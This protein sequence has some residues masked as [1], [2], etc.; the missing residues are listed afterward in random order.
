L[1]DRAHL[2]AQI[3]H[4][5]RNPLHAALGLLEY[6]HGNAGGPAGAACAPCALRPLFDDRDVLDIHSLETELRTMQSVLNA[7]VDTQ[8]LEA[9]LATVR[10]GPTDLPAVVRDVC[11]YHRSAL[12]NGVELEV[13]LA[14]NI[15]VIQSDGVRIGQVR[16]SSEFHVLGV[17]D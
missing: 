10:I 16:R 6:M 7:V 13:C 5:L 3:C 15:P 12:C 1:S 8:Q 9:G 11:Q 2:A 4:G 14:P 17:L